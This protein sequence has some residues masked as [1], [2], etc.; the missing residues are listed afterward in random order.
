MIIRLNLS[1]FGEIFIKTSDAQVFLIF[2]P[3]CLHYG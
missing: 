2:H 1:K 3:R